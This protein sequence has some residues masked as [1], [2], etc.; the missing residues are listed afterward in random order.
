MPDTQLEMPSSAPIVVE[1]VVNV[2][3]SFAFDVFVKQGTW[4]PAHSHHIANTPAVYVILE[5]HAGGRWFERDKD[6][7]ECP[8]GGVL[9]YEPPTRVVLDWKLNGKW[10]YDPDFSCEVEVRFIEEGPELTR[11][12][13]EHRN[14][15]RYGEAMAAAR[16]A[17][18]S[19]HG[20]REVLSSYVG[21]V[22]SKAS[23]Q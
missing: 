12:I 13:L 5:P 17:L 6:G 20:W 11:V 1:L 15:E 16:K 10:E 3:P 22:E 8:W 7:N 2:P 21:V 14:M 19:D 18:D 9:A 4:W 23:Q